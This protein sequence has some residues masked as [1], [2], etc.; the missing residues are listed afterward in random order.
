MTCHEPDLRA[1]V[2]RYLD[3][4]A[5]GGSA[6]DIAALYAED[7]TL[8]D[9]VAAAKVHRPAVTIEGFYKNTGALS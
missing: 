3:T 1:L 2:E 4:V 5:S 8:E 6:A 9:P 7:A